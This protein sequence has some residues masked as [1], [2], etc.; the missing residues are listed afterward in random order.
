MTDVTDKFGDWIK[1][2]FDIYKN[3]LGLLIVSSLI[4]F[5]LSGITLGIL[6][7]PM[8]AGLVLI[9]LK[10][11]DGS[12]PPPVA[13]DVFQGFQFFLP[14]FLFCIVWGA[15]ILVASLI[16]SFIPC[17]G[18]VLTICIGLA[19]GAFLMFG[20]FLIVDKKMDFW[21]ASMASIEKVK[22]AFFPFLGLAVVAGIIGE[23]G[24]LACGIGVIVTMPIYFTILAVTYRDVFGSD[25]APAQGSQTETQ[26]LPETPAEPPSPGTSE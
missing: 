21:S 20:L 13:G 5:L 6:C 17:L 12:Q 24:S 9:V 2:G 18:Q 15:I 26:G 8:F 25:A 22:P 4:A 1:E 23:I 10:L 3:N 11:R 7:G 14:S 16:L 19:A